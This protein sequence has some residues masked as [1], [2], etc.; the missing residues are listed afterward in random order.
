MKE[1]HKEAMSHGRQGINK[2]EIAS[3]K[4]VGKRGMTSPSI[5]GAATRVLPSFPLSLSFLCIARMIF[6]DIH[7]TALGPILCAVFNTILCRRML[8]LNPGLLRRTY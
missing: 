2:Q 5:N 6:F 4:K 3:M 7:H 8:E 1:L